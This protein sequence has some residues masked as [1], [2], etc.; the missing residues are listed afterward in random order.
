MIIIRMIKLCDI[1]L[2][3]PLE[4]VFQNCLRSGKFPAEWKKA[5]VVSKLKKG[6]KQ[7]IKSYRPISPLLVCGKLFERLL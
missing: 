2:C 1:S 4:I 3:K 7:C 6:D 5:N